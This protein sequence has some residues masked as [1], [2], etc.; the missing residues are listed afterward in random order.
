M[1][2]AL[3]YL[4]PDQPDLLYPSPPP[5]PRPSL[6]HNFLTHFPFPPWPCDQSLQD[7]IALGSRER[8]RGMRG[9]RRRARGRDG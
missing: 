6:Q 8:E 5:N 3:L 9:L 2:D 7:G 1:W 4:F